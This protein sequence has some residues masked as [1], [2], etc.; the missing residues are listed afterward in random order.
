MTVIN[1][2]VFITILA[3][4]ALRGGTESLQDIIKNHGFVM[5]PTIWALPFVFFITLFRFFIG[6]ILHMRTLEKHDRLQPYIWLYDLIFIL[7][8]SL[9]FVLMGEFIYVMQVHFFTLLTIAL[10]V[11]GLWIA[12]M[13]PIEKKGWRP[14]VPWAWGL[15]NTVSGVYLVVLLY[16]GMPW[17]PLSTEAIMLT[18]IVFSIAAIIDVFLIDHY[19]LLKL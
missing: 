15:L 9:L 13:Y 16:P 12:S 10:F 17:Y 18:T 3:S 7:V 6:N 14:T 5:I 2:L 11:D 1:A 4:I 8:E 19:G